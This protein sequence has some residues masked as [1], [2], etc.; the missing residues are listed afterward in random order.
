[1]TSKLPGECWSQRQYDKILIDPPRSGALELMPRLVALGAQRV[2]YV[3]C[4]PATL[5][6]DVGELVHRYGFRLMAA[7][8][9]DMFPHTAHV[10][11]IAV[12]AYG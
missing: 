4:H 5:A 3:S 12:L 6:R 11:S 9:V 7:G 2:V 8:I 1:M 10:E